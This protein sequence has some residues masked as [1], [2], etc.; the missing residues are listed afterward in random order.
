MKISEQ[1]LRDLMNEE[2]FKNN[3]YPDPKWGW[4]VPTIGVGHTGPEVHPGLY[5]SNDQVMAQLRADVA[6]REDS[7]NRSVKVKLN[8]SQFDALGDF[9]FNIGI[10]GF[11]G[12]TLLRKLNA[13]DYQ[14]AADEFPHWCIPDLLIPRRERERAKFLGTGVETI[15]PTASVADVQKVLGL[16]A[17]GIYGPKTHDA[18]VEY[19]K[20]HGLVADGII[21]PKT[22]DAMGLLPKAGILSKLAGV[23]A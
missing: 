23:F 5:W 19:Q 13:G 11:E 12:S 8:Q 9:E 20:R 16:P 22:L 10:G 4:D 18:L 6:T 2:G 3:A 7:L 21:G 17:D 15:T 14:G 1:G